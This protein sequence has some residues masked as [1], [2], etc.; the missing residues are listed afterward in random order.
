MQTWEVL[1]LWNIPGDQS[2]A[3]PGPRCAANASYARSRHM[4]VGDIAYTTPL[5]H[6]RETGQS[7]D[8]SLISDPELCSSLELQNIAN[9]DDAGAMLTNSTDYGL[10]DVASEET[11]RPGSTYQW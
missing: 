4:R 3:R 2:A 8:R 7:Y 11:N 10:A 5:S 9:V 6:G 1:S